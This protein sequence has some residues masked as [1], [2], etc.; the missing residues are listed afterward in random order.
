MVKKMFTKNI[1]EKLFFGFLC[2]FIGLFFS[3]VYIFIDLGFIYILASVTLGFSVGS[4]IILIGIIE[5][6]YG[7]K[8]ENKKN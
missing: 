6:V 4:F 1:K 7:E 2:I 5:D 8:N 3:F